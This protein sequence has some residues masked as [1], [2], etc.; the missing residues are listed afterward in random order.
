MV[1]GV[2][3]LGVLVRP[4]REGPV[5]VED[6]PD[7]GERAEDDEDQGAVQVGVHLDQRVGLVEAKQEA[8]AE[9]NEEHEEGHD[10]CSEVPLDALEGLRAPQCQKVEDSPGDTV[11]CHGRET[12]P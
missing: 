8:A 7:E 10:T 1:L 3:L 2:F 5:D 9:D 6:E 11:G 4:Q 12:H